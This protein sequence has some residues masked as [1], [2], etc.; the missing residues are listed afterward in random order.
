MYRWII[1]AEGARRER[2][3][4][5]PSRCRYCRSRNVIADLH[6]TYAFRDGPWIVEEC[7]NC[8][9]YA[10]WRLIRDESDPPAVVWA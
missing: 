8:R 6:E 9:S 3:Y 5:L 10:A 2:V 7:F 4:R 1:A